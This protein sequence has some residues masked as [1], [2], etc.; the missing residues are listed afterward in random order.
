MKWI[1]WA[2]L[3]VLQ[4]AS[5]TWVSR[6]RNSGS[7]W[8]HGI[9]AVASNGVWIVSQFILIDALVRTLREGTWGDRA[10]IVTFYT[11]FTV[12]GA[13]GMHYVSMR[14]LETGKRQVGGR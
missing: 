2:L 7:L 12:L 11:T 10:V 5:F 1:M 3:L 9:A 6:A 4:N 14:W 8:Y 13:V